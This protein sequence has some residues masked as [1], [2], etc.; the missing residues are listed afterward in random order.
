MKCADSN[1]K[2]T[3]HF[4]R[5]MR[6]S[7]S[8]DWLLTHKSRRIVLRKLSS[9]SPKNIPKRRLMLT[10]CAH[11]IIT[12]LTSVM[13]KDRWGHLWTFSTLFP[14]LWK[15]FGTFCKSPGAFHLGKIT[16][17]TGLNAIGKRGLTGNFNGRPFR[18]I[19]LF[20][21][22]RLEQTFPFL[23]HNSVSTGGWGL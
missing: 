5:I 1:T 6:D 10:L 20:Y 22:S 4:S 16:G 15:T 7:H 9:V 14:S 12:R 19:P 11:W 21:P 8:F 3:C 17:L 2:V 13:L 23:L 18:S